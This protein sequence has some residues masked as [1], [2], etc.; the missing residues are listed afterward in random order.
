MAELPEPLQNAA[1]EGADK[2]FSRRVALMTAVYAVILAITSLGGNNATKE[3]LLSQQ[4]ASDQWNFYQA[5][6]IREHQYRALALRLE[7]DL[8]ERG[9]SM[10]PEARAKLEELRKKFAE[11]EKR[12]SS[13]KKDIEKDARRLEH[14]RD[15]NRERDPNFDFSEALLQIAIVLASVSILSTSRAL[16]AISTVFALGG[17]LLGLNGYLLL[18]HLPL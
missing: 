18:L 10:R 3:M 9:P 17:A 15:R 11:E 16:F 8:L 6:V 4:Q 13:E 1:E 7:A 2:A 5:K 12:Y 14:E